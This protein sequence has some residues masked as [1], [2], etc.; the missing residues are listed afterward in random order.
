MNRKLIE[1]E[2]TATMI[3]SY[4]TTRSKVRLQRLNKQSYNIIIP[5]LIFEMKLYC[6]CPT[7]D[8]SKVSEIDMYLAYDFVGDELIN[9]EEYKHVHEGD[10]NGGEWYSYDLEPKFISG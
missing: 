6:V 9:I 2:G 7:Y 3:Y 4:F 10:E 8:L 5:K 1:M